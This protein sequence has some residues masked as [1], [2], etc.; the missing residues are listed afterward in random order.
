MNNT[1]TEG[2]ILQ[3][4]AKA[5]RLGTIARLAGHAEF[6]PEKSGQVLGDVLLGISDLSESLINDLDELANIASGRCA[7]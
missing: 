4:S 3:I 6:I 1:I 2:M 7:V 5:E